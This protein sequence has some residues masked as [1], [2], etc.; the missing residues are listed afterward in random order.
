[1]GSLLVA[2]PHMPDKDWAAAVILIV[3]SDRQGVMG[4]LL[5]RP[6]EFPLSHLFP[7]L[8][9]AP[10]GKDPLYFG[11]L[12]ASGAR[13]VL[14]APGKREGAQ[15]LFS[16]VAVLF[17]SAAVEKAARSG[18][19]GDVFRVYAGYAGWSPEQL[20]HEVLQGNWRVLPG[21]AATVFDA[22]P[23][24]LWRRLSARR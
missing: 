6:T 20:R 24:T 8:R 2:S 4:L 7:E 19:R 22:H 12:V 13:A 15:R 3:Y 16:D 14:R 17:D 21:A 11:G 18:L 9:S 1:M 5:N 10:S 23:E